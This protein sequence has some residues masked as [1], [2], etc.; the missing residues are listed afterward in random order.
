MTDAD[1]K[2]ARIQTLIAAIRIKHPAPKCVMI[3]DVKS[4]PRTS[5]RPKARPSDLVSPRAGGAAP[6]VQP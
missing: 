5:L 6:Q 3:E 4:A 1:I 2:K